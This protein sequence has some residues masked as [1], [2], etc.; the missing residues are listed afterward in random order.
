M[1][2]HLLTGILILGILGVSVI[3]GCL[4]GDTAFDKAIDEAV[5]KGDPSI[6][7]KLKGELSKDHCYYRVA[8]GMNDVS[9][10]A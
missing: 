4:D 10:C 5:K 9:V 8:C 2:K 7:D 1:D 3:S 6:C